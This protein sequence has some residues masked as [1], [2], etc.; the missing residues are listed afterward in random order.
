MLCKAKHPIILKDK[1]VARCSAMP[2]HISI[3][4]NISRWS[5]WP[6]RYMS[7]SNRWI[8]NLSRLLSRLSISETPILGAVLFH[9]GIKAAGQEPLQRRNTNSPGAAVSRLGPNPALGSQWALRK[10]LIWR[11][12]TEAIIG[13]RPPSVEPLCSPC[14]CP[15]HLPPEALPDILQDS[16]KV[17]H[18]IRISVWHYQ[19]SGNFGFS[20]CSLDLISYFFHCAIIYLLPCIIY[21]TGSNS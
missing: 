8:Q 15:V 2:W 10:F 17:W 11:K 7:I 19:P 5:L 4:I 6:S 9:L 21:K 13:F 3:N 14:P 12:H 18:S 1:N 16:T 20:K